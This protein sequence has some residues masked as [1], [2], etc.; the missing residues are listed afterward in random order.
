[1]QAIRYALQAK[2]VL[3]RWRGLVPVEHCEIINDINGEVP[4]KLVIV[5]A[6]AREKGG[7]VIDSIAVTQVQIS[8]QVAC[9]VKGSQP[10]AATQKSEASSS[11]RVAPM[12]SSQ[13]PRQVH[14]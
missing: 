5:L 13:P 12:P 2:E 3:L 6:H 9:A 8:S 4:G 7:K 10:S 1:M 14:D 11:S